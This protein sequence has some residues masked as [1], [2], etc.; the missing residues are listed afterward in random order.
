MIIISSF[1]DYYDGYA[2]R[3]RQDFREKKWIREPQEIKYSLDKLLKALGNYKQK[4]IFKSFYRGKLAA[5]ESKLLVVSGAVFPIV[6]RKCLDGSKPWEYFY[7]YDSLIT[8]YPDAK[9]LEGGFFGYD[10]KE[11]FKAYF[12]HLDDLCIELDSPVLLFDHPEDT[13]Y[14]HVTGNKTI[15]NVNPVLKNIGF[16]KHMDSPGVY[17]LLDYFVSN[18]LVNDEMPAYPRTDVEKLESHGFDKKT[19]FRKPKST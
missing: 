18:V 1:K 15:I 2:T 11:F 5:Y 4:R 14:R 8:A 19:S 6:I 17:Q 7:S 10:L 13:R 12:V 16:S 9:R 3:D